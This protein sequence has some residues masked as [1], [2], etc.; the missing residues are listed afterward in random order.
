[1]ISPVRP[2][3]PMTGWLATANA[4]TTVQRGRFVKIIGAWAGDAPNTPSKARTGDLKLAVASRAD[5]ITVSGLGTQVYPLDKYTFSDSGSDH[6]HDT[7]AS[8]EVCIYWT[9]GG[10]YWTDEYNTT[11]ITSSTTLGTRL[12]IDADGV[13]C[14]SAA[15]PADWGTITAE[16]PVA[17]FL[18]M[19]GTPATTQWY[20]PNG[21]TK[22]PW[23]RYRFIDR[24]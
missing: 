6:G 1:M 3:I 22:V 21:S 23:I 20:A 15:N 13:L 5:L 24:G 7:I 11:T 18:G 10:E 16:L 9:G 4:T 19:R 12:Y 8:G 14:A 2:G 17:V